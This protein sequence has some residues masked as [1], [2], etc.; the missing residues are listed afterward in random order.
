MQYKPK[1]KQR[2][3]PI[4]HTENLSWMEIQCLPN[5]PLFGISMQT[6]TFH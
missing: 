3:A 6:N 5:M 1:T 4:P 2:K